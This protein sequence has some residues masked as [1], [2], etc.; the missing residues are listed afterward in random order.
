[1]TDEVPKD[2]AG[3]SLRQ[4]PERDRGVPLR[5]KVFQVL[6]PSCRPTRFR[7]LRGQPQLR[8]VVQ[9]DIDTCEEALKD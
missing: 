3:D 7:C 8:H 4:V 1:M 5:S 9:D 2:Q 6:N